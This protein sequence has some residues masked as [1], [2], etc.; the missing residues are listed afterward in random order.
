MLDRP[1]I[2]D[3]RRG[4]MEPSAIRLAVDHRRCFRRD[5]NAI[6]RPRD[7]LDAVGVQPC[8][9][10]DPLASLDNPASRPPNAL[11]VSPAALTFSVDLAR[12]TVLPQ[13]ALV[14]LYSQ[15]ALSWTLSADGLAGRQQDRRI[16]P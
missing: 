11:Q 2:T 14:L 16:N 7:D 9:H 5:A 6:L 8:N 1:A 3:H 15:S 4:T 13:Q 10:T 12:D